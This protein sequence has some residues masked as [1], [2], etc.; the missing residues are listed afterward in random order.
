MSN[1]VTTES[2]GLLEPAQ[3]N[4]ARSEWSLLPR[5][6]GTCTST[7]RLPPTH[8]S[9]EM[10]PRQRPFCTPHRRVSR[11]GDEAETRCKVLFLQ[12]PPGMVAE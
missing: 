6:I 5:R 8:D 1:A 3:R 7:I 4:E 2:D 9:H 12:F 11:N 10:E